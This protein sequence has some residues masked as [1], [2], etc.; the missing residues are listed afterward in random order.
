MKKLF[1]T[2]TI[3]II[4]LNAFSQWN[5]TEN[6][7]TTTKSVGIGALNPNYKLDV[8]GNIHGDNLYA[9]S[10]NAYVQLRD[11]AGSM[12]L[13]MNNSG[14]LQITNSYK[15][16]LYHFD[17]SGKLGVGVFNPQYSLDVAG[18][19][20][21]NNLY[22]QSSNAYIQ[23]GDIVGS[24]F[25]RMNNSGNLQIT[26]SSSSPLYHFDQSGKLGIG[27]NPKRNA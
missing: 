27:T 6:S 22:V 25:L 10:S 12:F 1:L 4:S 2:F 13:R 20:H 24:M 3:S 5:I 14:N 26:N 8:A 23:M 7:I 9:Q 21:G 11:I 19:I 18:N 15:T 16:P 17:Q